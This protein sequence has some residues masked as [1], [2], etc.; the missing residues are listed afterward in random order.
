MKNLEVLYIFYFKYMFIFIFFFLS[1]L[2]LGYNLPNFDRKFVGLTELKLSSFPP[3]F[4][5][6]I[7]FHSLLQFF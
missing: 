6:S 2:E 3:R 4:F 7:F 1:I 5:F